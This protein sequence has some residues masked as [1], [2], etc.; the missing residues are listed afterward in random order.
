MELVGNISRSD[1]AIHEIDRFTSGLKDRGIANSSINVRLAS[2]KTFLRW[3]QERGYLREIPKV[4]VLPTTRKLPKVL[5]DEQ[6]A[7]LFAHIREK[8]RTTRNPDHRRQY[9]HHEPF[10]PLVGFT[11]ASLAVRIRDATRALM[12]RSLRPNSL[13]RRRG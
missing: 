9:H 6:I 2:L 1:L 3:A 4:K 11:G 5:S 13:A 10:L 12:V 8:Q 7:S